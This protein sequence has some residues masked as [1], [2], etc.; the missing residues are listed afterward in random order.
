MNKCKS[1]YPIFPLRTLI[2]SEMKEEFLRLLEESNSFSSSQSAV[3]SQLPVNNELQ[4]LICNSEEE[5]LLELIGEIV[6]DPEG[7]IKGV[8]NA[9]IQARKDEQFIHILFHNLLETLT[10][11]KL[12]EDRSLQVIQ[13]IQTKV[14][15][16]KEIKREEK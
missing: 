5:A 3:L 15:K 14:S 4:E 1:T 2:G 9:I 8:I 12:N 11:D 6:D 13:I 16:S 10:S 7:N